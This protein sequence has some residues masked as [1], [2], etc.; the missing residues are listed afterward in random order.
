MRLFIAIEFPDNVI[1]ELQSLQCEIQK[2]VSSGRFMTKENLHLTLYFL[3]ETTETKIPEI[4]RTLEVI[5]KNNRPFRLS[6]SEQLEY[7]GQ[8][9]PVRVLWLGV[10]ADLTVLQSLQTIIAVS[11]R[12]MGFVND[13]GSYTPHITLA[14]QAHFLD[15]GL[16]QD[17]GKIDFLA[18][19]IPDMLANSF[20]LVAS[21]RENGESVYKTIAKFYFEHQRQL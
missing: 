11:M 1:G 3:G 7:F 6:F 2:K 16:L 13:A 15:C 21:N 12:K 9:N 4:M 8:K 17:Y 10:N 5:A 14:R 18:R 20:S 19:H